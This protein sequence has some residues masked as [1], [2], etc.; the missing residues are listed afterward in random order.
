MKKFFIML[1]A[2]V[3]F[4]CGI[5]NAEI[6]RVAISSVFVS[7]FDRAKSWYT[8]K[9]GFDVV[10]D[11]Q[12]G[13]GPTDRWVSVSAKTDPNFRLVFKIGTPVTHHA[14]HP[15]LPEAIFTVFTD[16][17]LKTATEL[18]A[19]GVVFAIEPRRD[20]WAFEA[21]VLDPDGQGIVIAEEKAATK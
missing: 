5:A 13:P 17:L 9:L 10:E 12:Y 20:P 6:K 21:M 2:T 3:A 15:D 14:G 11:M 4:D 7:D 16:D 19:R 8:Q 18:K 1:M